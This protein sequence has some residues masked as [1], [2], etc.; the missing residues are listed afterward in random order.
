MLD[1]DRMAVAADQASELLRSLGHR[2]RL[3]VLCQLAEGER[4]VG[5]LAGALG[6]RDSTLSQHLALLRRAGLVRT[7]R[8]GQTIWYSIASQPARRVL[9]TLF[10]IF[11]TPVAADKRSAKSQATARITDRKR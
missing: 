9:Q 11:C 8:D 5:Y 2:H 1:S 7:R 6:L 4:S 3:L 10:E